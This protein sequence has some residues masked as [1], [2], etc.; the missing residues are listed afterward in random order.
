MNGNGHTPT[1]IDW[2]NM[3]EWITTEEAAELSGYDVQHV[4]RLMR[5]NKIAGRKAGTMWWIDTDSLKDYLA[6]IA[7]LGTKKYAGVSQEQI[8]EISGRDLAN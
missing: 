3:P 7:A 8:E 5:E 6:T 2:A 4:R 1:A